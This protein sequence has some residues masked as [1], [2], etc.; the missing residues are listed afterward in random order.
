MQR[1]SN[2]LENRA[3]DLNEQGYQHRAERIQGISNR[4]ERNSQRIKQISNQIGKN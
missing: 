1:L 3:N 2:W 4:V